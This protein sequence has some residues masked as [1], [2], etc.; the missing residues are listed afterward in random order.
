MKQRIDLNIEAREPGKSTCRAL[1]NQKRIP[2]VIYGAVKNQNVS[3]H[4]N[5]VVK[6]NTRKY[7]NTLFSV[8]SS[9]ADINGKI[10]LIKDVTVNPLSRRPV[11]VDLY[12]L[13]LNKPVRVEV[14]VKL[15]GKPI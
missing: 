1:R 14:E 8:K 4:E 10:A 5:D 2:A 15:E 12:A 9:V 11:H 6:Y 13:D 3:L 7:D